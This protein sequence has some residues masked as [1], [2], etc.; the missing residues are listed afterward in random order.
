MVP[1]LEKHAEEGQAKAAEAAL[2]LVDGGLTPDAAVAKVARKQGA[3]R[4]HT[5]REIFR[6]QLAPA[7]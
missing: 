1:T 3:R 2:D 6:R 7:A 4:R 5:R